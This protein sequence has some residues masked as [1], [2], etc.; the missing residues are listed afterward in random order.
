VYAGIHD[1]G[2]RIRPRTRKALA[3][4]QFRNPIGMWP[5]HFAR[6]E[7]YRVG[8]QL[9]HARSGKTLFILAR[10]VQIQPTGYLEVSRQNAEPGIE[11]ILAE[12]ITAAPERA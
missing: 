10:S 9:R 6:G 7:L 8:N 5:R 2:G 3:I 12:A 11:A 1:T 4:P